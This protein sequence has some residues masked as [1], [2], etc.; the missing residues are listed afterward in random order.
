IEQLSAKRDQDSLAKLKTML[1]SDA[2]YGVR[3]EAAKALRSVH[4]DEALDALLASTQQPDARVRREVVDAIGAFYAEPAL[5]FGR[6]VLEREKNPAIQATALRG[7]GAYARPEVRQTL[8]RFLDSDS[9]RN[10]LAD[11]AIAAMRLQDDPDY[12]GPLLQTLSRREASFSSR[13]FAQGLE[14]LAY[15][16]RNEEKKS[17]VRDFLAGHVTHKRRV[18]RVASL[19]AL[20]RLGD[21]KALPVVEKWAAAAKESPERKAAEGALAELRASRKPVDDFKNL[22]EEVLSLQKAN[23][24][25]LKV[26]EELKKRV[27][28]NPKAEMR[29]SKQFRTPKSEVP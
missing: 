16:A 9:Y 29:N 15:L 25:F 11:A 2:F 3:L 27:E 18:I 14:A 22:R 1:N 28:G 20:G 8:L 7:L 17:S 6:Q 12:V 23:R 13:G 19:T 10:E 24:D 4:T 5:A 26:L 21:P